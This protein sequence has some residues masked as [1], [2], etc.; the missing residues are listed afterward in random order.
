MEKISN[1]NIKLRI[2]FLT[3]VGID[4]LEVRG[5]YHDLLRKFRDESHEIFIICPS[6]RREGKKPVF[7]KEKGVTIIKVKTLNLQKANIIEKGIATLILEYQFIASI[8]KVLGEIKFDLILY[9]TPP[10]TFSNVISYLKKRDNAFSYLLLKDIFPQNAID[11]NMIKRNGVIHRFFRKKET[12]LYNVSDVIGCMSEANRNYILKHNSNINPNRVHINPN[13]IDPIPCVENLSLKN[14]LRMKYHIPSETTVFLYGGNL[15]KPQG[16]QFLI[17]VMEAFKEEANIFFLIVGDGTEYSRINLWIQNN[18]PLNVQLVKALPKREFDALLRCCDVGLI[19]LDKRFTIP[20]F[21]SRIL[22]YMEL[23]MPV[24][25]ATDVSTDLKDVIESGNF[26]YW[27]ESGDLKSMKANIE[28][29]ISNADE[30]KALGSYGF[31]YLNNHYTA[32][33]SYQT[34][35]DQYTNVH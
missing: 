13:S 8:K 14:D 35:I 28:K 27:C 7:V 3:I 31:N 25:A 22:S 10:V 11:L 32:S 5:I 34:I 4:S 23:A 6:E 24:L 21:P 18:N 15:G 19:F 12:M 16:I 17:E 26:G 30:I 2:L 9:S 29:M 1:S 33:I 20:N